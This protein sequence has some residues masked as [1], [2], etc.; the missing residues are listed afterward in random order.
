M[1]NFGVLEMDRWAVLERVC[2]GGLRQS[3]AAEILGLSVR[4][5]RRLLVRTA[6]VGMEGLLS[7]S[8]GAIGRWIRL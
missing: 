3:E 4:Q 8:R 1:I 7:R 6:L 2:S 5:V